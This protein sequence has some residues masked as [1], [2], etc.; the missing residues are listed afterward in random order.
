[1]EE[2][3]HGWNHGIKRI[4][5][6]DVQDEEDSN[7]STPGPYR[8]RHYLNLKDR[9]YRDDTEM[10]PEEDLYYYGMRAHRGI[11]QEDEFVDMEAL[12]EM[13]EQE[14]GVSLDEINELFRAGNPNPERLRKKSALEDR[15]LEI[16]EAGGNMAVL[17]SA[18]GWSVDV[19]GRC[20]TM[21]KALRRA[22]DRRGE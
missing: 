6:N 1:M 7:H 9:T 17:A 12:W 15:F 10:V 11:L 22:K 2:P 13:I 4:D 8:P 16:S 14:L 18:I 5:I 19:E 20:R 21:K 3:P